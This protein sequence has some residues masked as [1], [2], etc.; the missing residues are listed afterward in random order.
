[1]LLK[2]SATVALEVLSGICPG[3]ESTFEPWSIWNRLRIVIDVPGRDEQPLVSALVL[4]GITLGS[5]QE[6]QAEVSGESIGGFECDAPFSFDESLKDR[7][8]HAAG[9]SNG[10]RRLSGGGNGGLK[11]AGERLIPGTFPPS[12]IFV[13][14]HGAYILS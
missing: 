8:G 10:V 1:V 12:Q 7:S 11:L 14:A 4:Y 2:T 3:P 13:D 6:G 9:P 5:R